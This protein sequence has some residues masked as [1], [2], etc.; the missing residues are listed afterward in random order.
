MTVIPLGTPRTWAVVMS[1]A[2]HRCHC[3]GACGSKHSKTAMQCDKTT[4]HT[5]MLAAPADLTLTTAAAATVPVGELLAWCTDCHRKAATRQRADAR[6]R[7]RLEG[8]A[9]AGLFDL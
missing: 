3:T 9:P 1:A 4:E 2:G 7:H 8:D 6:E 5:Q